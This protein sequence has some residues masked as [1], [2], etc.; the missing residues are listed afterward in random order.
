MPLTT[1]YLDLQGK[2]DVQQN[3]FY[4]FLN[5]GINA[6]L[7]EINLACQKKVKQ[8]GMARKGDLSPEKESELRAEF[9]LVRDAYSIL[10]DK[11]KRL[12]YNGELFTLIKKEEAIPSS[13]FKSIRLETAK[14]EKNKSAQNPNRSVYK[15]FFGFSEKPFH[16]SPNP[17]YLYLSAKHKE[18]LAPPCFWSSGK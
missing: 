4:Q 3:N 15:D 10:S 5:V 16:L 12:A 8:I 2:V 1:E 11:N 14:I 7:K 18:V 17:K 13:F 6:S 9:D